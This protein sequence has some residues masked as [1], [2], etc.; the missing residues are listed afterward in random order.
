MSYPFSAA[1]GFL[2]AQHHVGPNDPTW[3]EDTRLTQQ[4]VRVYGRDPD[5]LDLIL[6]DGSFGNMPDTP[7]TQGYEVDR[8]CWFAS[9]Q[10]D[11]AGTNRVTPIWGGAFPAVAMPPAGT[12]SDPYKSSVQSEVYVLPAFD[13]DPGDPTSWRPDTGVLPQKVATPGG[14]PIPGGAQLIVLPFS[15]QT[16]QQMAAFSA[17]SDLVAVWRGGTARGNLGT[18]EYDVRPDGSL[19]LLRRARLQTADRIWRLPEGGLLAFGSVPGAAQKPFPASSSIAW[20]V[21]L[22]VENQA[23]YGSIVDQVGGLVTVVDP[24]VPDPGTATGTQ[25]KPGGGGPKTTG[26]PTVVQQ[27]VIGLTGRRAF[28]G[29]SVGQVVDKHLIATTPD[30]E[31]VNSAHWWIKQPVDGDGFDAPFK[32]AGVWEPAG[33]GGPLVREVFHRYDKDDPHEFL[34]GTRQGLRKWQVR[35][36]VDVTPPPRDKGGFDKLG[37]KDKFGGT[38]KTV[39]DK[40]AAIDKNSASDKYGGADKEGFG[41]NTKAAGEDG[42]KGLTD[43]IKGA[44]DLINKTGDAVK[45]IADR[46]RFPGAQGRTPTTP[47]PFVPFPPIEVPVPHLPGDAPSGDPFEPTGVPVPR[48]PGDAPGGDP[49]EPTGVPVPKLPEHEVFSFGGGLLYGSEPGMTAGVV[50]DGSAGT[51]SRDRGYARTP[52][53]FAAPSFL[54]RPS[55]V[56]GLDLRG[57]TGDFTDAQRAAYDSPVPISGGIHAVA[58]QSTSWFEKFTG[59][60]DALF[61][62]GSALRGG[63]ALTPSTVDPKTIQNGG[64]L[65][66]S[67]PDTF[68]YLATLASQLAFSEFDLDANPIDG[69][70]AGRGSTK[71]FSLDFV[72]HAGLSDLPPALY[73]DGTSTTNPVAKLWGGQAVTTYSPSAGTAPAGTVFVSDGTN[74]APGGTWQAPGST[75]VGS[76]GFWGSGADGAA[77]VNGGAA[78]TGMTG[79]AGI[80]YTLSRDVFYTDLTLSGGYKVNTN[81]WRVYVSGTLTLGASDRIGCDGN[82]AVGGTAGAAITAQTAGGGTAGGTGN[83]VLA[84]VT[85]F[86]NAGTNQTDSFGGAGGHGGNTASGGTIGGAAGGTVTRPASNYG[87][88]Y[89]TPQIVRAYL[90]SFQGIVPLRGGAGGGSGSGIGSTV[91]GSLIEGAGG[92]G[93]GVVII[94]ARKLV[95]AG[96]ISADGGPGGAAQNVSATASY[97]GGGGGGGGGGLVCLTYGSSGSTL[98]TVSV[99]GGGGGAGLSGGGYTGDAGTAGSAGRT[100]ILAL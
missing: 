26:K 78:P 83:T 93:A 68:L 31:P 60:G 36:P 2:V 56:R 6:G 9:G 21:G 14:R 8:A 99:A 51:I 98:G 72:N 34:G 90:E 4:C 33:D 18:L 96:I 95:N 38:D 3:P 61:S 39:L 29:H 85:D 94:V 30:G 59:P 73:Y 58:A 70:V 46:V 48:L 49:F 41:D 11:P 44:S 50:E 57:R 66:T 32:P 28:G 1:E 86:G 81:G 20:Q 79:P 19:D 67:L 92:G 75:G 74:G 27:S 62:G 65:P 84:T 16:E 17:S 5:T 24:V 69:Y 40:I 87:E 22:D 71:T 43:G 54:G 82:A 52:L 45:V 63:F 47:G 91:S 13:Q 7:N 97:A 53:D 35:V 55:P 77:T 80:V 25:E 15:I 10:T 12:T 42:I 100:R 64:T 37:G 76:A 23:G 88:C 89:Q